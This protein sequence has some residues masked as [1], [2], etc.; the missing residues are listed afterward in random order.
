MSELSYDAAIEDLK[1]YCDSLTGHSG[2]NFSC[3]LEEN[4]Q[5]IVS[6][7]E[8]EVDMISLASLVAGSVGATGGIAGLLGEKSGFTT[9]FHEGSGQQLLINILDNGSILVILFDHS[10]TLG[11]VRFQVRKI[12]DEL[13]SKTKRL[14]DKYVSHT[15]SNNSASP[16][17]EVADEEIDALF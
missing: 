10:R 9:L 6:S 16:F 1:G 17:A 8:I 2:V 4:G 14:L 7:G 15:G 13:S 3:L 11:W 12:Q 5:I